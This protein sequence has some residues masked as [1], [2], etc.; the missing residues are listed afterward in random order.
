MT[1]DLERERNK[2]IA[3][4]TESNLIEGIR[5][6]PTDDQIEE[7]IH[8]L[9]R[10]L[11][12]LHDLCELALL[13]ESRAVLRSSHGMDVM[14][15]SYYPPRGGPQIERNLRLL[16]DL[17]MEGR[18]AP[19]DLH[20]RYEDLHPFMDGNGRTGRVLWAWMMIR[21]KGWD[22]TFALAFLH[23][24]YYQSLDR[25]RDSKWET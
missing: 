24:W 17:M 18:G 1:T 19:Y 10:G 5:Q 9:R 25:R 11:L 6:P 14:V 4:L 7:T 3:F 16:L 13:F 20:C 21:R 22:H 8:F 15:G 12:N 2:V 23:R